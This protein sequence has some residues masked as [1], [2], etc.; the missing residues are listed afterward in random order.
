MKRRRQRECL[1]RQTG[2][3]MLSKPSVRG[4]RRLP[5]VTMK[6]SKLNVRIQKV[7]GNPLWAIK[8]GVRLGGYERCVPREKAKAERVGHYPY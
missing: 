5:A 4:A 3:Q 7:K 2:R 6:V 1:R 8:G